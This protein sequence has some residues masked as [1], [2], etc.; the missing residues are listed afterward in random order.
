MRRRK[1]VA[2]TQGQYEGAEGYV[3]QRGFQVRAKAKTLN[4]T[5]PAVVGQPNLV[6]VD[7]IGIS[8]MYFYALQRRIARST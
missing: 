6:R 3:L 1:S 7:S 2:P 4:T 5:M 8:I